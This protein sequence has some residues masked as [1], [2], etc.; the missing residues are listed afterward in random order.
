MFIM[1]V[2]INKNVQLPKSWTGGRPA[3]YPWSE[4]EIG[5][6]FLMDTSH[7]ATGLVK[8]YNK[9]QKKGKKI[10]IKTCLENGKRRVWRIA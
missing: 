2:E 8:A 3:K 9:K 5:D 10:K 6:S 7:S 1:K 4:L